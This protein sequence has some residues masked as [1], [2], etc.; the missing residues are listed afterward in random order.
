MAAWILPA[1]AI[2]SQIIGGISQ[3]NAQ[4]KAT[5]AKNKHQKKS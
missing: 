3:A 2:G 5:A 1:I 4:R